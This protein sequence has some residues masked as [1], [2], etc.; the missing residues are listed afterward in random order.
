MRVR[1][2]WGL[3]SVGFYELK[4]IDW[5]VRM[6]TFWIDDSCESDCRIE[7]IRR[8]RIPYRGQVALHS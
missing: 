7:K 6:Y 1:R 3:D 8:E 4:S 5:K 2:A